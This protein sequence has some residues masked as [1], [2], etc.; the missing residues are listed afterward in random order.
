[1]AQRWCSCKFGRMDSK[2]RSIVKAGLWTAIGF[3]MM[4]LTGYV[5]TGSLSTGGALAL[6]NS[7]LGM[8]SYVIYE[9]VWATI[10]WGRDA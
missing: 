8:V 3:V 10:G 5:L 7:G 1:M 6:L 4:A 9:R 2:R